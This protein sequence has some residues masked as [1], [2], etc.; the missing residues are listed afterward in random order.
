VLFF[1]LYGLGNTVPVG[2]QVAHATK[3]REY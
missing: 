3:S 1:H 2:C